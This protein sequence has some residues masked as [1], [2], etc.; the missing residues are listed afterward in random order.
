MGGRRWKFPAG[1]KKDAPG[2][3]LSLVGAA[4]GTGADYCP[5]GAVFPGRMP[6]LLFAT[7]DFDARDLGKPD[8]SSLELAGPR[9]R[10][11]RK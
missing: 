4:R 9:L 6:I 2:E 10:M 3:G 1:P 11:S 8:R 5:W 7:I